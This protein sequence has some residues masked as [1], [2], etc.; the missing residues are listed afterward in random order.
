MPLIVDYVNRGGLV[1]MQDNTGGYAAKDTLAFLR[2][3]GLVL[4]FWPAVSPNLNPIRT[5]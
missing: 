5:L 1:L 2:E 4:I 3:R